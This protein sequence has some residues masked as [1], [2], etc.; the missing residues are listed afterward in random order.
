MANPA[1]RTKEGYLAVAEHFFYSGWCEISGEY[2]SSV[3]REEWVSNRLISQGKMD[4]AGLIHK[5]VG[6]Y[7]GDK[8]SNTTEDEK[9]LLS[10][11]N[12]DWETPKFWPQL[13]DQK[14]SRLE[15]MDFNNVCSAVNPEAGD[16]KEDIKW[17]LWTQMQN[18]EFLTRLQETTKG[19]IGQISPDTPAPLDT[20]QD[21]DIYMKTVFKHDFEVAM[22]VAVKSAWNG[23]DIPK[24]LLKKMHY[25]D[26]LDIGR[27][28]VDIVTNPFDHT[29]T[30]K[31]VDPPNTIT[32]EFRAHLQDHPSKCAYFETYTASEL[33]TMIDVPLS[34]KQ[35]EKIITL[36]KNY[37][38]NATLPGNM[39]T[40][41]NTD[42]E[43]GFFRAFNVAVMKMYFLNS[44]RLKFSEKNTGSGKKFVPADIDAEVG[45]REYVDSGSEPGNPKKAIEKTTAID[46]EYY[47]QVYWVV[48]TDIVFQYGKCVNQARELL[49]GQR[50]VCPMIT[51]VVNTASD[52]DRVRAFNEGARLAWLKIQQAKAAARPKGYNIDI[53][54]LANVTVG[55]K[56]SQR[57]VLQIFNATG[58]LIW[59]SKNFLTPE[60][61][62]NYK[63]ITDNE[64]GLGADYQSWLDDLHFNLD[65]MQRV[66]GLN[67]PTAAGA[68]EPRLGVGIG[69]M[70]QDSTDNSLAQIS[71]GIATCYD[72]VAEQLA[73]KIQWEVRNGDKTII[74]N[75]LGKTITHLIS[76]NVCPHRFAY[77]W[78]YMP[79]DVMKQD[80]L[81]SIKKVL[82]NPSTPMQSAIFMDDYFYLY[83]L[84]ESP[85]VDFKLVQLI[86]ASIVKKC[87]DAQTE[88]QTASQKQANSDALALSA[89]KHKE[90]LEMQTLVDKGKNDVA[91][92]TGQWAF[93]VATQKDVN[94]AHRDIIKG[95]QKQ[96]E[97]MLENHP[98]LQNE[99]K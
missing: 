6:E 71:A 60:Q 93:K 91:N 89:Q 56:I 77:S 61:A 83:D 90:A 50:A 53:S 33:M 23:G 62:T 43:N 41:V 52:T 95:N 97:I 21:L 82:Q 40:I 28:T 26:I 98:A 88:Q 32:P 81:D 51:Y 67:D 9:N 92:T 11:I 44:D 86:A 57:V 4:E 70:A 39:Q 37:F 80:L 35:K 55:G 5:V 96:Q 54:A 18:K 45:E 42:A 22:Q 17:Q 58:R 24:K 29:S 12:L 1:N 19:N 27:I 16:L 64:G 63:P 76:T 68:P 73:Q 74:E 72:R 78:K 13:R 20:R 30:V 36:N 2:V 3:K 15:K 46:L 84:I 87:L 7:G 59:A 69:E 48:G 99:N 47:E 31:Y 38:T 66:I 94:G 49:K 34:D 65:N 25:E 14:L 10:F 8:N 75:S 79:T 85:D